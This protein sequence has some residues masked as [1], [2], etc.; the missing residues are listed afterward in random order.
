MK[1]ICVI[2]TPTVLHSRPTLEPFSPSVVVRN[3]TRKERYPRWS[4]G[5]TAGFERNAETNRSNY[6][7]V[8][9]D[10]R[11]GGSCASDICS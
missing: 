9:T 4:A 6:K 5:L 8:M 10:Q 11:D 3:N 1:H 7:T 2:G